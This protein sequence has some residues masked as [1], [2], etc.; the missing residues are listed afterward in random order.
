MRSLGE[1]GQALGLLFGLV[2]IG[3]LAMPA[4]AATEKVL[5]NFYGPT[6]YGSGPFNLFVGQDGSLYGLTHSG[7][8]NL[9]YG[10][11][12]KY[13]P[14]GVVTT[15]AA[16]D[17]NEGGSPASVIQASDGNFYG[18]TAGWYGIEGGT[19]PSTLFK[20]T[21][22]GVRTN[23]YT[24]DSPGGGDIIQGSDGYLYIAFG[25]AIYRS[26][27]GGTLTTLHTFAPIMQAL[28]VELNADG[29]GPGNLL[30]AP[31][32]TL[33]GTA[34]FG[35][36][37]GSGTLFKLT[38]EGTF[39][40]LYA[41][42]YVNPNDR[43]HNADGA[44]PDSLVLGA[45]GALYGTTIS[46]GA[47]GTGT[48]FRLSPQNS[49]T[50]LHTFS[51]LY[52]TYQSLS[53]ADGAVPTVLIAG[54]DGN[55]YGGTQAGGAGGSGVVFKI[56]PQG[57]FKTIHAFAAVG[58]PLFAD[59]A[60]LSSLL[61]NS[62]G[63]F[64]GACLQGGLFGDGTVFQ[65][66][67]RVVPADFNGDGRSDLLFQ[68]LATGQIA[69]W[70]MNGTAATGVYVYPPQDLHWRLVGS[71]DFN[72]DSLPDLV[73]QNTTTGRMA[74][75]YMENNDIVAFSNGAPSTDYIYPQPAPGWKCVGI[76]DFNGDGYPDLLFSN[77][78]T[79]QLAVWFMSPQFGNYA[80]GGA[81][82]S[83]VQDPHWQCVGTGDFNGDGSPDL[84][85]QNTTTGQLAVWYLKGLTVVGGAYVSK[86]QTPGWQAVAIADL[87]G[88]GHPDIVFENAVTGQ[89][90]AW[91]LNEATV[92]G[93]AALS[94]SQNQGWQAA[95]PR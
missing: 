9:Y 12:F 45:D 28:D 85:F 2:L 31:D 63:S 14:G 95:G 48:I 18:L 72:N 10:T 32:G 17:Y 58:S 23:L 61:Q 89:L 24:F 7:G 79:G 41:F 56:T 5:L 13:T 84:L 20:I 73:F 49:L 47:N 37:W 54:T 65:L 6:P 67:P 81:Y 60:E 51:I 34:D 74:V 64:T 15:I 27:L 8:A 90:M 50:T 22:A 75:W 92:T 16:F 39:T 3:L 35:G 53:N 88:D 55:F 77:P 40:L 43:G 59:G 29:L 11:L 93:M 33:Y 69:L 62:D 68:N 19:I 26:T 86:T 87:N 38:P 91:Y 42:A 57:N 30:Q 76:N 52:D 21:P 36:P 1:T 71:G 44:Y 4:S 66:N 94:P 46:G 80:E 83:L 25:D 70:Y 82:I 78:T